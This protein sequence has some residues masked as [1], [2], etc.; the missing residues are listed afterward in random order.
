[1]TTTPAPEALL[2]RLRSAQRLLI[3]SHANP[4][5]DAIGTS[6]GLARI[7][8][9]LGKGAMIWHRDPVPT[10]YHPLPGTERIH[11]GTEPPVGFPDQYDAAVVLECPTLDRCG[12]EEPISTLPL[13]NIDHHLGNQ[14]YG[15]V[16]WVDPTA[17]AVGEM[18]YRVSRGLG[19]TI[20]DEIAAALYMALVTD[21]GGFRFGNT[22]PA[23]FESA[24][25]LV[26][27][28]AR[29]E[30][31]AG[32]LYDSRPESAVRLV[33]EMLATLELHH[34]G[35]IATVALTRE[36]FSRT[37]ATAGD[38]EGL[39][40]HPRSIAGVAAVALLRELP[41]GEVKVSLR[42][43]GDIDVEALAR[44]HGGGG[45]PNAAGMPAHGDLP[46]IRRQVVEELAG[47]LGDHP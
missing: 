40:D 36:M 22:S 42:S 47:I 18:I 8:N 24:A 38:A 2:R 21:T 39:I 12:L 31:V 37:N 27:D 30:R 17:P 29:P 5:G 43:S 35:R 25:A 46:T 10:L 7:L 14:H 44:R 26:R 19:L 11:T 41:G 15:E 34:D 20:D 45:H 23:A 16:N 3:T 6:V 4:D 13:L 32:W 9:R 28:G 33:G 1:M